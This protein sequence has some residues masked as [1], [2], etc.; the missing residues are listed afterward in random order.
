[1]F[2]VGKYVYGL[3][4]WTKKTP[5]YTKRLGHKQAIALAKGKTASCKGIIVNTAVFT[6][7]ICTTVIAMPRRKFVLFASV[8]DELRLLFALLNG[9]LI[10]L[11]FTKRKANRTR[12]YGI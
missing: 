1:M 4:V 5:G 7:K 9:N 11:F 6:A 8:M 10:A 12:T 3:L 2:G